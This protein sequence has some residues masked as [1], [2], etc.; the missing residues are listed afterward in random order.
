MMCEVH[1]CIHPAAARTHFV[2]RSTKNSADRYYCV[3]HM[4]SIA[5]RTAQLGLAQV[6]II[7]TGVRGM[8]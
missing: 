7:L 8:L 4:L 1:D 6:S 2:W 3:E 5:M